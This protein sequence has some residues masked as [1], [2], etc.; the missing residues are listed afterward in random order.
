M[1]IA[2]FLSEIIRPFLFSFVAFKIVFLIH[3]KESFTQLYFSITAF[4]LFSASTIKK[5]A[6]LKAVSTAAT[7][8]TSELQVAG[9]S[10][11]LIFEQLISHKARE[12]REL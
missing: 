4:T 6:I 11:F 1:G 7:S 3:V 8:I 2:I 10:R 12:M 5:I 9:N